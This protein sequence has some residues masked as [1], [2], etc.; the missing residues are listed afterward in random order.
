MAGGHFQADEQLFEHCPLLVA[1]PYLAGTA[2]A[3]KVILL[4]EHGSNGARG[5]MVNDEFQDFLRRRQEAGVDSE[6]TDGLL[7]VQVGVVK[8]GPGQL[9]RELRSGV[10]LTTRVARD[11]VLEPSPDLWQGLLQEIGR[12]FYRSVLGMK[13]FPSHPSNN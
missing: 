7:S 4:V 3:R 9:E 2:Y 1:T 12:T 13:H 5:V 11:R 8:W 10:W 6:P